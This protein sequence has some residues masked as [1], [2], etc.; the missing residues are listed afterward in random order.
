MVAGHYS[1][2]GTLIEG[3]DPLGAAVPV[4]VDFDGK[5]LVDISGGTV[6][7]GDV[8]IEDT[9]GNSIT[10]TAGSLNVNVTNSQPYT[11]EKSTNAVGS[12]EIVFNILTALLAP[13]ADRKGLIIQIVS[14]LVEIWLGSTN[15]PTYILKPNSVLEVENYTGAV[16]GRTQSGSTSIFVTEKI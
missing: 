8:R 6:S 12:Q 7:V 13:N 14:E 4:A 1:G 15:V 3:S 2:E 11:S 16:L 5:L 9:D 10:T